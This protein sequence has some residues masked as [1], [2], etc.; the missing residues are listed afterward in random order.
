MDLEPGSVKWGETNLSGVGAGRR[1]SDE[2]RPPRLGSMVATADDQVK[3]VVVVYPCHG[4]V[5]GP[6]NLSVSGDI[7]GSCTRVLENRT[8]ATRGCA[9]ARSRWGR[10]Y[11]EN[12]A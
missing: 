3:A 6:D 8:G 12:Q 4:T 11:S 2:Q 5:L 7:V 9:W 1:A 10:E